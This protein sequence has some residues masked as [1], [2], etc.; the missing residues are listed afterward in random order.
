MELDVQDAHGPARLLLP[1][2]RLHLG[3][4]AGRLRAAGGEAACLAGEPLGEL[5]A[6][7]S[8]ARFA[9]GTARGAAGVGAADG[10][11]AGR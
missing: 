4:M 5:A 10:T 9:D 1:R 6:P 3:R 2:L 7:F 11:G 8:P